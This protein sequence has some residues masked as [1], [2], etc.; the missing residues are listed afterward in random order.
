MGHGTADGGGRQTGGGIDGLELRLI[1]KLVV[2]A[3]GQQEGSRGRP[4]QHIA[5]RRNVKMR[6]PA[7]KSD[8]LPSRGIEQT[9]TRCQAPRGE[10]ASII[11]GDLVQSRQLGFAAFDIKSA[12]VEITPGTDYEVTAAMLQ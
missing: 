10:R 9:L 4:Q 2:Q 8:R 11:G 7:E 6:S 1:P 5:A 12:S 3:L